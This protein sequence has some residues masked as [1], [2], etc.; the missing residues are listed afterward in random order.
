MSRTRTFV[1]RAAAAILAGV[2]GVGFFFAIVGVFGLPAAIAAL[3]LFVVL[4]CLIFRR[5]QEPR[6]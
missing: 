2:L 5:P 3:L 1:A 4:A 6:P